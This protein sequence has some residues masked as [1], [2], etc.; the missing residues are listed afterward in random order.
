MNKYLEHYLV[1]VKHPEVSGFEHLEML[2]IRDKLASEVESLSAEEAAQLEAADRRLLA[3]A[4]QFYAAL[5]QITDLHSE[6]Q[7]R[8]PPPDRWWWYLDVLTRLPQRPLHSQ[9][10][11]L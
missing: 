7:Y 1:A 6:R 5:V 2:A 8:Q 3:Q 4:N 10:A 11:S 9:Y